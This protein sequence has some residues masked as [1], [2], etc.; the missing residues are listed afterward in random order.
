MHKSRLATI[1]IDATDETASKSQDFWGGALGKTVIV[2]NE[3][4]SAFQGRVGGA[5]GVYIG[6]QKGVEDSQLVHLDIETDDVEAEVLRLLA[7]GATVKK[8]I[9]NH[10]VMTAPGRHDFCVVPKSRGDFE[11]NATTW[12]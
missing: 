11:V 9:R 2:R 1:V 5:G 6:H 4:F 10:V 12:E 7:L 8:R 3:R